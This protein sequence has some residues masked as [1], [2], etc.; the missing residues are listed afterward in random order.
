MQCVLGF[1]VDVR[2]LTLTVTLYNT[3]GY[4]VV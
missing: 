4:D 3:A 2:V 1:R